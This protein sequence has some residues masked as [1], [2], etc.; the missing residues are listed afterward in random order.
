MARNSW[1][2]CVCDDLREWDGPDGRAD[3][4]RSNDD[5]A[6]NLWSIARLDESK[7]DGV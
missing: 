4:R 1:L 3:L 5:P 2:E 6:F 7:S